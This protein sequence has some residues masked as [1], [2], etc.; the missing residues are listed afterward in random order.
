MFF[1]NIENKVVIE[2]IVA[3]E[4]VERECKPSNNGDIEMVSVNSTS[5]KLHVIKRVP[6]HLWK[7]RCVHLHCS[8]SAQCALWV[9]SIRSL[10]EKSKWA[11][12]L[13]M[14]FALF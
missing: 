6:K 7:V 10:L 12:L 3:V 14:N 9:D 1:F 4:Y 13:F 8:S 11:I 5:F 2:E